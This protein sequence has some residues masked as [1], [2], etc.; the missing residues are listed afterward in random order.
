MCGFAIFTL[1]NIQS[2]SAAAAAKNFNNNL[3]QLTENELIKILNDYNQEEI[4]YCNLNENA[5]WNVQ[6]NVGDEEI[7]KK[8]VFVSHFHKHLIIL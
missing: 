6:T 5:E 8:F 2:T 4:K 1:S 7:Q 3:N